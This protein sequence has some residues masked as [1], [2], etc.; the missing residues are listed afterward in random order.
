MIS[1]GTQ[2][3]LV[4]QRTRQ[5]RA[6][7]LGGAQRGQRVLAVPLEPVEEVL[8]VVD[9]LLEVLEE[10]RDRVAD[11]GDV[12]FQRGAERR[13]HVEVPR[14]AEDRDNG[15]AGLDQGLQIRSS[16]GRTPGRRVAPKA[17]DLRGLEHRPLHALEEAEVLRVR[18][19]PP[20]F[21][22]VDSQSVEPLGDAHL[23]FHGE[24]HALALGA[25]AQRR[26]VELDESRHGPPIM[27]KPPSRVKFRRARGSSLESSRY[28]TAA[29][30]RGAGQGAPSRR[31]LYCASGGAPAPRAPPP[32]YAPRDDSAARRRRPRGAWPRGILGSGAGA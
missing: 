17:D 1:S 4:S 27:G 7:R 15:R 31:M 3:P 16:W 9:H 25:V 10:I 8:G 13:R 5:W 30:G 20:A 29:G 21:Y 26:I 19:R 12:L 18:A 24:G 2:P 22:V 11:H 28:A 6:R 32:G 23:V 14:L